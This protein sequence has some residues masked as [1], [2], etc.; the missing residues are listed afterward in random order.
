LIKHRSFIHSLTF[1]VFIS[2]ALAFYFPVVSL[3]FFLGYSSHLVVDSFTE[4]GIR[5]FWPAKGVVSGKVRTG[6]H[7]EEGVFY[8]LILVNIILLVVLLV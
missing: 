8:T 6:G 4:E 3:P 2:L 5:V 7:V 1:C